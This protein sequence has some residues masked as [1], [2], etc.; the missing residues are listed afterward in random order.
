MVEKR[1]EHVKKP[2]W[3]HH[4]RESNGYRLDG[5]DGPEY[6]QTEHLETCEYMH[7]FDCHV[8]EKY[9]IWLVLRRHKHYHDAVDQLKE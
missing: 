6:G 7:T 3:T 8:A 4:K 5:L 1:D 9:V 2:Q